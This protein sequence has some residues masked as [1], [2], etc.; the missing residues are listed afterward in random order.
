MNGPFV[1]AQA[2]TGGSSATPVQVLKL[3]KP[4]AGETDIMHASFTGTV[5]IDFTAIA[6]EKITL[7]HDSKNQS[8]H[9]IFADGSQVI[10]EPFFDSTG[11][12][13][14]NLLFEM[15]PNQFYSGEQF[16][17]TYTISEDPTVLPATG[18]TVLSGGDFH[19]PSVDP[20]GP[21]NPLD[22]LPPEEL[23]GIDFTVTE[24]PILTEGAPLN[25]IP[26]L[27][28]PVFGIVEE[29]QLSQQ[30][31]E[32]PS[33]AGNGNEDVNDIDGNDSDFAPPVTQTAT[34][35]LAGTVVGGDLPITFFIKDVS[36][37]QVTG[38]HGP[39][40]SLGLPV[41]YVFISSTEIQAWTFDNQNNPIN[42]VFTLELSPDG[43]FTYTLNDQ[44]DHFF[45][46][47]DPGSTSDGNLE[48]TLFIDLS[49][50]VGGHDNNGDPIV[51][52]TDGM[53]TIGVID[54]TPVAQISQTETIAAVDESDGT[55]ADEV[56]PLSIFGSV[57]DPSSDLPSAQ[58]AQSSGSVVDTSGSNPGA[59]GPGAPTTFSLTITDSNS[60]LTTTDGHAI[61]L[62]LEGGLVIGRIV[63]GA[64]DGNA[65]FAI[66]ID[67][68]SGELYVVQYASLHHNSADDGDISEP[69]DL[70]GKIAAVVTVT[71]F[72]GDVATNSVDIG[73]AVNFLDD[74]PTA[75]ITTSGSVTV[76]ESAG[77]QPPDEVAG[78]LA[79]FAGVAHKGTDLPVAQF[80]TQTGLVSAAGSSAGADEEGA[81]TVFS[82]SIS[83]DGVDSGLTTTD[84]LAI[85]LFNEG[86]IIVGRYDSDGDLDVDA[87]DDAAFAIAINSTGDVSV[88]QYVSLHHTSADAGDISEPDVLTGKITAV[89][90][91][92]DG[93][94]DHVS[95]STDIGGQIQFLDDGPTAVDEVTQ[96]LTESFA[97]TTDVLAGT[98]PVAESDAGFTTITTINNLAVGDTIHID[99]T[100]APNAK[101]ITWR[102]VD[103]ATNNVVETGTAFT[104]NANSGTISE[105]ITVAGNYDLQ[106][107]YNDTSGPVDASIDITNVTVDHAVTSSVTGNVT[108]NDTFGADEEGAHISAI[109]Y[110]NESNVIAT[111]TITVDGDPLTGTTVDSIFG[112][113]FINEFG[114]YTYTAD[115]N[116]VP[117]GDTD[118]KVT[119]HFVYTLMDGDGDVS[120]ANMDFDINDVQGPRI[121]NGA[122]ITNTASGS[123]E[124]ILTFVDV[125]HP[126]DAFA[127][128][129]VRAEEGQQGAIAS[130]AGFNIDPA[131]QYQIALEN[132]IDG[133]K[134]IVTD[135]NL[136]GISIEEAAGNI[137]LE[138]EGTSNKPDGI[139]AI[140][141]PTG[142]TP[143]TDVDSTDGDQ[144]NNNITDAGGGTFNFL[145]GAEG[146]D[147]LAGSGDSDVLN[148]GA[149][150]DVLQA[151]AGNDIL[152]YDRLDTTIDGGTG[153]DILRIDDGALYNV[154]AFQ[155]GFAVPGIANATVDLFGKPITNIEAI[156]LTEEDQPDAL[157]GTTL[158]DGKGTVPTTDDGLTAADVIAFTGGSINSETLT[159]NTLFVIG[160][161]GDKVELQGAWNDTHTQYTSDGGQ[162]FEKYTNATATIF[163][164]NDVQVHINP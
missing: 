56:G 113:L 144:N 159:A 108:T 23:P 162:T 15:G 95:A 52:L 87:N 99:F 103:I 45:P 41:K 2:N 98:V 24:A 151:G 146:I 115:V 148:G 78:P 127:Q 111:A 61:T 68:T 110:T 44:I 19:D 85:K 109:T 81:T 101:S 117:D 138:R 94:G 63:G 16:A 141:S 22:L 65:A 145:Y 30:I 125:A 12:V 155:G 48:E 25:L 38:D 142:V 20:L 134:V 10:I 147:T 79:V 69:L 5:K 43:S 139:T 88:V 46:S 157:L 72:D 49:T 91:V 67:N 31:I 77:L 32:L 53:F 130:D 84:G 112:S 129:F 116:A 36:G 128:V 73:S 18:D 17:Q 8:L 39:V 62:S 107:N 71:D 37:Q 6:D 75:S 122:I 54:D 14:A 4:K 137:Q 160:S 114:D 82:L 106:I 93:D 76:D 136:E 135:F 29:E 119:D 66:A 132:P 97:Q 58:Y 42:K 83:A 156:L 3:I 105:A 154:G 120:T 131:D 51:P 163:I 21:S 164:D 1:V 7:F 124:M 133:H 121:L 9:V 33:D 27:G 55:Q 149:G 47:T 64:D 57:V 140:I 153:F 126:L 89:V 26:A 34:G 59:D 158:T 74:G 102:L 86:G 35:T 150:A 13:L 70:S 123:Q 90:T 104:G 143:V 40:T 152:V 92:T 60:G 118:S 80:A 28:E 96:T 100:G 161:E 50:V 11:T